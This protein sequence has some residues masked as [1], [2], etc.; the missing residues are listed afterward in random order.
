MPSDICAYLARYVKAVEA[1]VGERVMLES[2][3]S[4][5][6]QNVLGG[7]AYVSFYP[8][9]IDLTLDLNG[10]EGMYELTADLTHQDGRVVVGDI[11]K[12]SGNAEFLK[13]N[14]GGIFNDL[15]RLI[16]GRL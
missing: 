10:V 6:Y 8:S 16:S 13:E 1:E 3:S 14:L 4:G 15:V 2:S 7:T 9:E 11:F 12:L 5:F